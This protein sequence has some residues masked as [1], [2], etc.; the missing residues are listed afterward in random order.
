MSQGKY[1]IKNI[2]LLTMSNFA[3]KL[4]SFFLLPLYTSVLTTEQYSIYELFVT[5]V[6]LLIPIL[7]INIME[8]TLR[9]TLDKTIDKNE[10]FTISI[11]YFLKGCVIGLCFLLLNYLLGFSA[12]ITEYWYYIVL[13]FVINGFSGI[14]SSFVRGLDRILDISV[15]SVFCTI[16]TI[17][18]NVVFLVT[19]NMGLHGYFLANIIGP[20][21]QCIYLFIRVRG[22]HYINFSKKNCELKLE[23]INYSKPLIANSVAWWVNNASDRYIVTFFCGI[24][25]NG[26]YSIGYKIPSILNIFQSIFNQ[27]WTLSA[28]KDFDPEDKS[29]FFSNMY[30]TYN[31]SMVFLCSCLIFM[32]RI[33]A[34]FLYAKDF[35]EAWKYV[36]FL[37]IAIV[38]GSMSGYIGGIFSAVKNPKIFAKSTVIGAIINI[39]LN[40]ILIQFF[41]ALGAAIATAVAYWV[42]WAIRLNHVKTYI[43]FKLRL[44]RDYFAYS[45]LVIQSVVLLIMEKETIS[46]YT[47]EAALVVLILLIYL[48]ELKAIIKIISYKVQ[49]IIIRRSK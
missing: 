32:D 29:G 28:V 2:F 45:L 8:S 47:I 17:T 26:I 15:S 23:M 40:V 18:L 37:L 9:F 7:T 22:W 11:T 21:F 46:L 13:L 30:N 42:V 31:F 20:A 39:I 5:T 49:K 16:F 3:T 10:I 35:Y 44:V 27:A 12:I 1:L 6:T 36:P 41:G 14:I 24:A 34:K 48:K 43:K 38:F 4:L 19:F 25:A 33:L